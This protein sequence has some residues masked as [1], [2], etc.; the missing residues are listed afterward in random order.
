M[1]EPRHVLLALWD[2][3]R[4]GAERMAIDLA[5]RLP[6]QGFIPRIAALG[7]GGSLEEEIR[8]A[9]L[10]LTVGPATTDRRQTRAFSRRLLA[11]LPNG[12]IIHTHLGADHWLG[13]AAKKAGFPWLSTCHNDDRDDPWWKRRLKVWTWNRA[14]RV[15]CVSETVRRFWQGRGL[16]ARRTTVI[17][18][19]LELQRFTPKT[20]L[21]YHD[22]PLILTVGRL[23]PQK[24]QEWLL[25]ALAPIRGPWKLEIVGDGPLRRPLEALADELGIRGRVSFRGVVGDVRPFFARA[26]LFAFPSAW[27]GQGIS[28]LEA[29]ASGLPLLVSDRP[30]FREWLGESSAFFLPDEISAWTERLAHV[31]QHPEDA[32]ARAWRAYEDVLRFAP[33]ERMVEAYAACYHETVRYAHLARQ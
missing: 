10:E 27:E 7:G 2:L 14:D 4:G 21:T 8:A 9:G 17:P 25:R 24:R 26:D 15:V 12:T 5:R 31:L 18:N 11:S 32:Q 33:I 3:G 6:K 30:A 23:V 19:G 20:R 16:D 29:A 1:N 28:L 22:T 13:L